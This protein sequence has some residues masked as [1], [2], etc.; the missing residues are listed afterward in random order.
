MSSTISRAEDDKISS[1]FEKIASRDEKSKAPKS[2]IK[3]VIAIVTVLVIVLIVLLYFYMKNPNNLLAKRGSKLT[4]ATVANDGFG[5]GGLEV[6][7]MPHMPQLQ[8]S[9][10]AIGGQTSGTPLFGGVPIDLN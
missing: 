9:N 8:N 1:D 6:G 4:V 3:V 10:Y 2:N 5:S 7:Q